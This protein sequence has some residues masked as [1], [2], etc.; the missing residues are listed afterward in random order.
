VIYN[1]TLPE[2]ARSSNSCS[3]K[4]IPT[5]G[6]RRSHETLKTSLIGGG[7]R[8]EEETATVAVIT[9]IRDE[10]ERRSGEEGVREHNII[11]SECIGKRR[12]D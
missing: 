1:N 8:K 12:G 2:S 10:N 7:R 5:S 6:N 9:T 3:S 4:L 11:V